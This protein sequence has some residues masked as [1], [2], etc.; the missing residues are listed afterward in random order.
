MTDGIRAHSM[1]DAL[2]SQ[3]FDATIKGSNFAHKGFHDLLAM[4]PTGSGTGASAFFASTRGNTVNNVQDY[5]EESGN[6]PESASHQTFGNSAGFADS[7]RSPRDITPSV[8]PSRDKSLPTEP[9]QE[10]VE[11]MT[12]GLP[13]K[14]SGGSPKAAFPTA[15]KD[16][17]LRTPKT[18]IRHL[19][20][21]QQPPAMAV[22]ASI[23]PKRDSVSGVFA[24]LSPK[25]NSPII[26]NGPVASVAHRVGTFVTPVANAART[27]FDSSPE[28]AERT[29]P[30]AG[31]LWGPPRPTMAEMSPASPARQ[32]RMGRKLD[33]IDK[34]L[35][36]WP[37]EFR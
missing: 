9:W 27:I 11:S 21:P 31:G 10:A 14:P 16:L 36:S 20:S 18:P 26:T 6:Q 4:L 24:S 2:A 17:A 19:L 30:A 7:P 28:K 13:A 5:L 15:P 29:V 8:I 1:N 25:R 12:S 33:K 35:I 3:H 37:M 22:F 32:A 34:R 23:S